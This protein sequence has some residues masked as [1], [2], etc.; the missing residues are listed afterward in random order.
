MLNEL[1]QEELRKAG[2]LHDWL[3]SKVENFPK[4]TSG[5]SYSSVGIAEL[6]LTLEIC[7]AIKNLVSS[8]LVGTAFT[9]LRSAFE[10]YVRSVWL[11]HIA[12]EKELEKV[13][14]KDCFP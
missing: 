4:P 2:Q 9:L 7:F 3:Q 6:G 8:E 10:A 5:K 12:T 13:V 1:V 11:L 14:K